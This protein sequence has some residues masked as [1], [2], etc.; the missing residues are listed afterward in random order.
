MNSADNKESIPPE[1]KKKKKGKKGKKE[2]K[3]SNMPASRSTFH[4]I[5]VLNTTAREKPDPIL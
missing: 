1:K 3:Q 2:R 4:Q 5:C